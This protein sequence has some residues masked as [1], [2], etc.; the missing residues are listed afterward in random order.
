MDAL[1]VC[2][3]KES[4]KGEDSGEASDE[5][6]QEGMEDMAEE[7]VGPDDLSGKN[8][9]GLQAYSKEPHFTNIKC[10]EGKTLPVFGSSKN[11]K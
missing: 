6:E 3:R 10:L 2:E 9:Y 1:Q 5:F 4:E 11:K 7:L 8:R